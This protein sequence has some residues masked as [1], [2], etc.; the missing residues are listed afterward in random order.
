MAFYLFSPFFFLSDAKEPQESGTFF[1]AFAAVA[2]AYE[3]AIVT[4]PSGVVWLVDVLGPV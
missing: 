3:P 2:A 4:F 1:V